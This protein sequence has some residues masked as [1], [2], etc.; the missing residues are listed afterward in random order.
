MARVPS[1][2][3]VVAPAPGPL[4]LAPLQCGRG[5][6][7]APDGSLVPTLA[8]TRRAL[9]CRQKTGRPSLSGGPDG[10]TTSS[11]AG[12]EAQ[13]PRQEL[14]LPRSRPEPPLRLPVPQRRSRGRHRFRVAFFL[15]PPPN[16]PDP[17]PWLSKRVRI[18]SCSPPPSLL[19]LPKDPCPLARGGQGQPTWGAAGRCCTRA[20]YLGLQQVRPA[21]NLPH[22]L[23]FQLV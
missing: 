23:A 22:A 4:P 20:R 11:N 14:L 7:R 3:P 9:G 13:R 12:P 8:T 2:S 15:I 10:S 1:P 18:S 6:P 5:A 19:G 17:H 21:G 16:A